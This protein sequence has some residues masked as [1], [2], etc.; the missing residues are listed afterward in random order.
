MPEHADGAGPF[1]HSPRHPT[2]R[3]PLIS[4]G[5]DLPL[6]EL[7][8]RAAHLIVLVLEQEVT[9]GGKVRRGVHGWVAQDVGGN[10]S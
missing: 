3:L 7:P 2:G 4:V 8:H 9:G 10:L 5:I 6:D 1:K